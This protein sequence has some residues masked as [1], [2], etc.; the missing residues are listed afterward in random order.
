MY[1]YHILGGLAVTILTILFGVMSLAPLFTCPED[2]PGVTR[3]EGS[4]GTLEFP[5]RCCVPD[6]TLD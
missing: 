5:E 1:Y 3:P 2:E 6:A 4:P